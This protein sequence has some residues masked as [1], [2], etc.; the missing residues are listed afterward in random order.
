[1][2]MS[3]TFELEMLDS[4][5]LLHTP[6]DQDLAI[7]RM[8]TREG[9]VYNLGVNR[10]FF[11]LIV[12]QWHFDLEAMQAAITSGAPMPGKPIGT[13]NRMAS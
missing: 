7:F 12:R 2:T 3:D 5:R 6:E 10:E 11:T 8:T 9:K 4:V 1:M 13:P